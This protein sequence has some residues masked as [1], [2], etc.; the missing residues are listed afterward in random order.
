MAI[1]ACSIAA[2]S[3]KEQSSCRIQHMF[4]HR[5]TCVPGSSSHSQ[6]VSKDAGKASN[7]WHRSTLSKDWRSHSNRRARQ[8]DGADRLGATCK[9][10]K[11]QSSGRG[12]AVSLSGLDAQTIGGAAQGVGTALFEESPYDDNGKPLASTL[13]DYLLPAPTEL[14]VSASSIWRHPLP[15]PRRP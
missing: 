10:R 7:L 6:P 3:H 8:Q 13:I 12:Q 11:P 1:V 9:A 4:P 5:A 15:I 2:A 14:R